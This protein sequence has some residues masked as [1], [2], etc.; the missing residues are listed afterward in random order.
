M[1]RAIV[2]LAIAALAAASAGALDIGLDGWFGDY[3]FAR[4]RASTDASFPGADWFWGVCLSAA[5]QFSDNAS[6]ETSFRCDPVLRNVASTLFTF[7]EAVLTVGAGPLFGLFNGGSKPLAPGISTTIRVEIPG[8][9]FVGF[10]SDSSIGS[11]LVEVGD[12][13]QEASE[14]AFGGYVPGAL[15]S[16]SLR[17]TA[18]T[19]RESATTVVVDSL[20]A[21]A[22]R[23]DVYMKNV[24]Y[25]IALTF[26]WQTLR[27]S[28]VAAATTTHTLHSIVLGG[29][30]LAS[31][32]RGL[33]LRGG[34][35]GTVYS[36]GQDALIG[37]SQSFLMRAF[38]GISLNLDSLPGISRF[39]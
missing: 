28:W 6:L 21:Y 35:E 27:K 19:Q 18:F 25:Q 10:R 31:L 14:V 15:V 39:F 13:V 36:F 11:G 16:L 22:L 3:G 32:P 1:R 26:A 4:N 5:Q 33:S 23:T 9:A 29:E 12:Y 17:S 34:L 38:A 7:H 8:V 2:L 30:L 24:P 20:N 37:S